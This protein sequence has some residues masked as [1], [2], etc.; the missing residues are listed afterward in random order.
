MAAMVAYFSALLA[1]TAE[2]FWPHLFLI[3]VSVVA[4]FAVAVGIILESPKYSPA[5]HRVAI[6]LVISGVAVEAL[7]MVCL[8]VVDES[9]SSAQQE[10]IIALEKQ[11]AP[12]NLTDEQKQKVAGKIISFAGTPFDLSM[13]QELKSMRLLDKIED[14]LLSAKWVEHPP[15]SGAV[16]FDR[17]NRPKVAI[18]TVA[19]VW[20]LYPK[21]S[22]QVFENAA[23]QLAEALRAED[24][25]ASLIVIDPG[26]E[27]DLGIIHVWVGGKP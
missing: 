16:Q 9:I 25:T 23:T 11:I 10:K 26:D 24:I 6:A 5:T 15:L 18:R 13:Q 22:G 8:F 7:C 4:S 3:S 27:Q 1:G 19:G 12:R 2:P 20:V 14:A 21:R 17:M